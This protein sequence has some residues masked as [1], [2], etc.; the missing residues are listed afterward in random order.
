MFKLLYPAV[1]LEANRRESFG[2]DNVLELIC[3]ISNFEF[4]IPLLSGISTFV[5][6][7]C[8]GLFILSLY[9]TEVE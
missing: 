8:V 5:M 2:F 1:L 6:I 3:L 4:T 7:S 9:S